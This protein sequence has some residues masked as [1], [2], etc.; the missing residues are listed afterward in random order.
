MTSHVNA[1]NN[2][3]RAQERTYRALLFLRQVRFGT[4]LC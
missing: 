1:P 3:T 2:L 4:P